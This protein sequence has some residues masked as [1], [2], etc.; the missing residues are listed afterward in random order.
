MQLDIDVS[1]PAFVWN[2]NS[3]LEVTRIHATITPSNSLIFHFIKVGLGVVLCMWRES[4]LEFFLVHMNP[5]RV[6]F[7]QVTDRQT[8]RKELPRAHHAWAQ[9]GSKMLPEILK[10]LGDLLKTNSQFDDPFVVSD[11][12]SFPT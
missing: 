11:I 1:P 6:N 7:G 5:F 12:M 4:W 2:P 8:D 3:V 9:V 10:K